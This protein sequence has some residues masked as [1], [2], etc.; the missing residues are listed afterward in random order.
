MEVVRAGKLNDGPRVVAGL[1][2]Y[3]SLLIVVTYNSV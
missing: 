2:L 1:S 3:H